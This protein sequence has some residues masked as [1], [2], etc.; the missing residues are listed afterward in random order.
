MLGKSVWTHYYLLPIRRFEIIDTSYKI[1][2]SATNQ[3]I[4]NGTL[5]IQAS[6]YFYLFETESVMI[7]RFWME[8]GTDDSKL[9]MLLKLSIESLEIQKETIRSGNIQLKS[10][11]VKW[12]CQ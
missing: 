10:T 11:P 7:R 2:K 5:L 8:I 1:H 3:T 12:I 4:S 9:L 6:T